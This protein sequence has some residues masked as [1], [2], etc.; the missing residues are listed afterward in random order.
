MGIPAS[1]VR[2]ALDHNFPAPVL[3]AFGVMVPHVELVPIAEIDEGL[4]EVDD[5][6]LFVALHRHEQRWDGLVTNDEALLSLAKEMTVLS[7]TNLTLIVAAGEGH[8]PI[9]AVGLLLCHLNHICHH[10]TP[11]RPQVWKLTVSQKDYDEPRKYL[12]KIAE[13]KQKT[14]EELFQIHRVLPKELRRPSAT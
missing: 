10:T 2:L 7:Q 3:K 9:R 11:D 4:A 6:E 13:K 1:K 8:N 12:E 5:W 14:V